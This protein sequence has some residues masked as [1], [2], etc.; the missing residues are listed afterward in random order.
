MAH[1]AGS[2]QQLQERPLGRPPLPRSGTVIHLLDGEPIPRIQCS[3]LPAG[4]FGILANKATWTFGHS[5]TSL[6]CGGFERMPVP[7][8]YARVYC[9]PRRPILITDVIGG[10]GNCSIFGTLRLAAA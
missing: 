3:V 1:P 9:A 5:S 2:P 4:F 10:S 6:N 7:P 8:A